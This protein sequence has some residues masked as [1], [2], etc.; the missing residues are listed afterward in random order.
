MAKAVLPAQAPPNG[1]PIDVVCR[2]EQHPVFTCP[3]VPDATIWRYLNF[4]KLVSLI[5]TRRLFFA[6]VDTFEDSF[7]GSISA[8]T[9]MARRKGYGDLDEEDRDE[10]L[11]TL[12]QMTESAPS[13]MYANCWNLSEVESAAL[14]GL[15]VQ[16]EGGVAIRSTYQR[17]VTAID[18]A[19]GDAGD[20]QC[21]FWVGKVAYIDYDCD[22]IPDDNTFY[23]F[24]H[25]RRSFEFESELRAMTWH[26]NWQG[27]SDPNSTGLRVSVDLDEL[28]EAIY[29]SPAAPTWFASLVRSVVSRYGCVA[30]V[31]QSTM[32]GEPIY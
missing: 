19:V 29:V 24:V 7:E 6:R 27:E 3:N 25:K 20:P 2:H 28:I 11:R 15:Y 31:H 32:S 26:Q 22:L 30:P 9:Q 18:S 10:R 1:P 17:L 13:W 16:A 4:T 14:W 5:D 8:A 21:P 12:Q 23:P